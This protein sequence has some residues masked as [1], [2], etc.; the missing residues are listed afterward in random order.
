MTLRELQYLVALARQ[1]NFRRAAEA[2]NVSQPTLSTQLRKLEDELGLVL[3]ERGTRKVMLTAAGEEIVARAQRMLNEAQDI[4]A[5]AERHRAPDTGRL[6][7]GVFPTLGPYLLPALVPRIAAQFPRL[8]LQLIEE[9]SDQLLQKLAA[10]QIDTAL[11]ALP[12]GED[13]LETVALFEEPFLLAV[14]LGHAFANRAEVSLDDLTGQKLMLLEDGH[15]L[16]DQTIS[17]CRR[18]GA[19]ETSG[20]RATSLETLRQMVA[21]GM[22]ITLMPMLA[23]CGPLAENG[24]LRFLPF[25]DTPPPSRSIGM[26]WRRSSALTPVL[27]QIARMAGES[28][29][30]LIDR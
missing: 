30:D 10:G 6:R 1:K 17:L 15:C 11:L 25:T 3:V 7:L 12:S 19:N 4:L 5:I 22:G 20:F 23:T 24:N 16:R 9:K 8:E 2:C 26:V 21:A 29:Q 13:T 18:W 28:A 27:R 14:P